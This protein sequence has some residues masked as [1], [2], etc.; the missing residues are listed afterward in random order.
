MGTTLA[1]TQ[2]LSAENNQNPQ[3]EQPQEQPAQAESPDSSGGKA[4]EV[5]KNKATSNDSMNILYL[6]G[7]LIIIGGLAGYG[8]MRFRK[9]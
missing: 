6:A 5:S 9:K 4:Y 7:S 8:F 2:A 3:Q 1:T